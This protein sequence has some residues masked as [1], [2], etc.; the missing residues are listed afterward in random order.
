MDAIDYCERGG[1]GGEGRVALYLVEDNN[2]V[3][4][5][6]ISVIETSN[7]KIIVYWAE[8]D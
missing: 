3:E 4:V 2:R 1:Q 5:E 6:C 8:R 7:W